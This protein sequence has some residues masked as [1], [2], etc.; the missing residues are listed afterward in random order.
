MK[1]R[2]KRLILLLAIIIL[3]IGGGFL[4]IKWLPND[5]QEKESQTEL[6]TRLMSIV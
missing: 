3:L 2:R 1:K 5:S 6:Y 4:V